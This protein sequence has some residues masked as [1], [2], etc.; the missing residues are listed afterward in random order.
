MDHTKA[1]VGP[2][3]SLA[4]EES[5]LIEETKRLVND[6][7]TE[8]SKL[9]SIITTERED[10]R[11]T[12]DAAMDLLNKVRV[13]YDQKIQQIK[14]R[15]EQQLN[16]MSEKKRKQQ[17]AAAI[18]ATATAAAATAM[19]DNDEFELLKMKL[20][21]AEM[22]LIRKDNELSNI[23][24]DMKISERDANRAQ[25]QVKYLREMNRE[26]K[27]RINSLEIAAKQ[28]MQKEQETVDEIE[29]L[30][31][32]IARREKQSASQ[33]HEFEVRWRAR[34]IGNMG[35]VQLIQKMI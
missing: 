33:V 14:D 4:T 7:R 22:N 31:Q 2:R 11:R 30:K 20:G 12:E 8:T 6:Y 16:E 17:N 32:Q 28:H 25:E 26:L 23:K 5:A 10:R 34:L 18:N 13:K 21:E 24:L 15:Y 29:V 9:K 19:N 35:W 1:N 3:S 27:E